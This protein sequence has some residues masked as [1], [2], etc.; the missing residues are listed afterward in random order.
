[1]I[2]SKSNPKKI[3]CKAKLVIE[4]ECENGVNWKPVDEATVHGADERRI[5]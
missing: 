2:R 3:Q 5:E 1:M 4:N